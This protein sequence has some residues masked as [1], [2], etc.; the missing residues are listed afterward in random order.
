MCCE[1]P[2]GEV[3]RDCRYIWAQRTGTK[4]DLQDDWR[5]ANW[6][7]RS[8]GRLSFLLSATLFLFARYHPFFLSQLKYLKLKDFH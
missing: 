7:R 1:G 2:F 6:I 5:L 3:S 8:S 4:G